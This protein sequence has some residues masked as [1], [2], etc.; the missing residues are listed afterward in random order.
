MW[1]YNY[2]NLL[3]YEDYDY[4]ENE[5]KNDSA[6]NSHVHMLEHTKTF[7]YDRECYE[8]KNYV[9]CRWFGITPYI[10]EFYGGVTEITNYNE[11]KKAEEIPCVWMP[12]SD[13][14][15]WDGVC[16]KPCHLRRNENECTKYNNG[17][18]DHNG[19][20]QWSNNKCVPE[21][22]GI[23]DQDNDTRERA[24]ESIV[25][26]VYSKGCRKCGS[27]TYYQPNIVKRITWHTSDIY[28]DVGYINHEEDTK[29]IPN[30]FSR[31][32]L[33]PAV[34]MGE[35]KH[36]GDGTTFPTGSEAE[37]LKFEF[38][39]NG[40]NSCPWTIT[41]PVGFGAVGVYKCLSCPAGWTTSKQIKFNIDSN[42]ITEDEIES[43]KKANCTVPCPE[44]HYCDGV[45]GPQPCPNGMTTDGTGKS[46]INNCIITK[47]TKFCD[48][49]G[50][51]TLPTLQENLT[52]IDV[53][54]E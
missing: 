33:V 42:N 25:G 45:N 54:T 49:H 30:D 27:S 21:C 15:N 10:Q 5:F 18:P 36:C 11:I 40:I 17:A 47:D 50:C 14:K 52:S 20:C 19:F 3:G 9:S 23:K 37:K 16:T 29:W 34:G 32:A 6:Y 7:N 43:N 46:S 48:R 26:C 44:N 12:K 28:L 22:G 24:C 38:L 39:E 41:C 35:C 51:F 53:Q 13:A 31:Y 8:I 2:V 1:A 4:G